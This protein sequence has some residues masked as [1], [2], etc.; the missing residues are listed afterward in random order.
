[1]PITDQGMSGKPGGDTG[2]PGVAVPPPPLKQ[3]KGKKGEIKLTPPSKKLK[4][5]VDISPQMEGKESHHVFTFGRMNPPTTGHEKL[6]HKTHAI[7]KSKGA[8]ANIVLSHSHD[9]KK[10]PVPQDHK[11]GYVKKIHSGVHVTGS[12]KEHPTFMHHAKKAHEAGH[13][14]LHMVAGSDRVKEYQNTLNK[15]NG[16]PDH[17]NFKSITVH[18]AGHRDPDGEGVSGISGTKM[19]DH[20]RNGDHKSFKAGLPKSLHA[21]HKE[22][23]GHIK[24][25]FEDAE[26]MEWV[27]SLTD[28]ELDEAINEDYLVEDLINERV[29]TLMQR[30]KA[31]IKMR[32]L[33]YRVQRMR[34]LKRKRM[35]TADMLKRRARRQAR[36]LMRKRIAGPKGANYSALSPSEKMQIDKR[37]QSKLP[38][39]NK[40]AKRLMP[41]VKSAELVRLRAARSKK[42]ESVNH[43]FQSFIG[44]LVNEGTTGDNDRSRFSL[45]NYLNQTSEVSESP[46]NKVFAKL[47]KTHDAEDDKLDKRQ[48]IAKEKLK[49]QLAKSKQA[50]I[51][52]EAADIASAVDMMIEAIE[53]I[54]SKATKADIDPDLLMVEYVDGYNNPH[55]KQTPQQGGFA[56]IN[57]KIAEMSAAEKDKAEDIVKGMKKKASYFTKKYG[58]KADSVMYATANKLAQEEK[59][60]LRDLLGDSKF[61]PHMMYDPKTGKGYKAKTEA[62][63]IKYKKMGYG[64]DKPSMDEG[65]GLWANIHAKRKRGEKMNPKGHPDAPTPAEMKK[66]QEEVDNTFLQKRGKQ[67]TPKEKARANAQ[68]KQKARDEIKSK[69]QLARSESIEVSEDYYAMKDAEEHAKRDGHDYHKDVSVQ[70]KY[71][72][73]HMKKRGY[74]H[75][76][77]RGYG[78]YSYNKHGAGNKITSADHHGISES[79]MAM[80]TAG[81]LA[82]MAAK[83]YG[84]TLAK[85]AAVKAAPY[86]AAGAAAYGA[87]KVIQK[88]L[89]DKQTQKM[90][91]KA[92]DRA[93]AKYKADQGY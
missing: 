20:A 75:R 45:Q 2:N 23:A 91:N 11:I 16:H 64:H 42:Q 46:T 59:K 53:A 70:H 8:K 4:D 48:D 78:S 82:G 38:I 34:K 27:D 67:L 72:A 49:I 63:H 89:K 3:P 36:N 61:E 15:Y 57:R 5:I 39:I 84:P 74:T 54:E 55:G 6:I 7:A 12:S 60:H 83:A 81:K 87:K 73:Y 18:S 1:M 22:I 35:A 65:K 56:A 28:F 71:D 40:L 86:V 90:I 21:H 92:A 10:N 19:R 24:E 47:K 26:L 88:K 51:R 76:E 52:R 93:V 68:H 37:I 31:A 32:R 14:H 13:T 25:G 79:I 17:Y 44:D 33:K 77:Y 62:D 50:E 9:S 43:S 66:A 85:A 80:K 69:I 30:R 58:N 41:K 29:Y